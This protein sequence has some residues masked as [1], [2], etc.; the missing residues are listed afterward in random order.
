MRRVPAA[1]FV[2][3]AMLLAAGCFRIDLAVEVRADGSGTAREVFAVDRRKAI[4]GLGGREGIEEA[5][6][7]ADRIENLPDWARASP[8]RQDGLEGVV[9]DLDFPTPELL[10]PRLKVLSEAITGTV[11]SRAT[12]DVVLERE[13]LGWR[14]TA[15][16]AD[17][18]LRPDP[19][20]PAGRR[21]ARCTT[22]RRSA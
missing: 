15:R 18:D 22:A 12:S 4:E 20:R 1:T 8:Y 7:R 19:Q 10:G 3:G 16:Q 6:P 5:I 2:L 11:G 14:F 13:G 9:I 17:L 21:S